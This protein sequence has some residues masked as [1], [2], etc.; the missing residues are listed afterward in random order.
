MNSEVKMDNSTHLEE[1]TG[2]GKLKDYTTIFDEL[3]AYKAWTGMMKREPKDFNEL[4]DGE[5]E[6]IAMHLVGDIKNA[7]KFSD[8]AQVGRNAIAYSILPRYAG[9]MGLADILQKEKDI[10]LVIPR[11]AKINK[12]K[13]KHRVVGEM[14]LKRDVSS[15]PEDISTF[16]AMW[17]YNKNQI[18]KAY[19]H[20]MGTQFSSPT[21]KNAG[22]N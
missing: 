17:G 20:I 3:T 14:T 8:I 12:T 11:G 4:S 5:L 6:L 7:N 22:G 15:V 1:I 9:E 16:M 2:K 21:Q 19:D 18:I 13:H 10:Y